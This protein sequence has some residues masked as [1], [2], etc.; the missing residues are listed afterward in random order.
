[1]LWKELPK[2]Y[3]LAYK[4]NIVV[5][6]SGYFFNYLCHRN[7]FLLSLLIFNRFLYIFFNSRGR[8]PLVGNSLRAEKWHWQ[9]QKVTLAGPKSHTRAKMSHCSVIMFSLICAWIN[10]WINN[11]KAGDLTR[12]LAHYDVIV[13]LYHGVLPGINNHIPSKVW[14]K[15]L[16]HSQTPFGNG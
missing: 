7:W 4:E 5:L 11:R 12:H 10:Y 3:V 16:I 2:L 14:V 15:L 1:M 9:V 8:V 6:E 13:M